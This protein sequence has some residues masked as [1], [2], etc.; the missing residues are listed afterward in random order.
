MFTAVIPVNRQAHREIGRTTSSYICR[1]LDP[2]LWSMESS[3]DQIADTRGVDEAEVAHTIRKM[4]YRDF[5]Q[6][7]YWKAVSRRVKRQAG[8]KCEICGGGDQLK[9]HHVSYANHGWEHRHLEDLICLCKKCHEKRHQ[10]Q[11]L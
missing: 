7:S 11:D 6:T 2:Y 10:C 5:L 1:H 3:W 4:S 9:A 8:G